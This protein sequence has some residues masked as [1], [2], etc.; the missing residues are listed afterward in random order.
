MGTPEN[1]EFTADRCDDLGDL[2]L[3]GASKLRTL[4]TPS[5]CLAALEDAYARLHTSPADNA[6]S[7]GFQTGDGKFHVKA[8]LYP[9]TQKYFAAKINANF[10]EN[11]QRS[12]LPTIQGVIVLC[13]G[14]DGHPL[15]ILQS[16]ELT[17]LRTAA[18]TALAARHGARPGASTLAMI[19]CGDQAMYQARALTDILPITRIAA[20]DRESS[21]AEKF[22]VWANVAL[23]VEAA[24][25]ASISEATGSSDI[26]V[27]CTTAVE[28]ILTPDMVDPGS[29]IAAVGADNPDKQELDPA[30]FKDARILVDDADQ[31]ASDGDLAHAIRAGSATHECVAAT[32]AELAAGMKP[33]R[34]REEQ[35][36]IF[37]STGTGLQDVAAAA[38]A[39]EAAQKNAVLRGGDAA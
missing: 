6:R 10:P 4:L 3:L 20:F 15:A 13:D 9:G 8:G 36:V 12:G 33:G 18:A 19:G 38:A 34:V 2:V 30:L 22:G 11:R 7:L 32:L 29:F 31:C 1:L 25:A 39:Y 14:S 37:D 28:A 27:T 17:G 21:K 26:I 5:L 24:P 16:G 23:G 35:I